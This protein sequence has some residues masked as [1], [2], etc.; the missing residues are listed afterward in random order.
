[1]VGTNFAPYFATRLGAEIKL[2]TA[3]V[4][5]FVGIPVTRIE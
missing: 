4:A 2:T 3:I 1:M 5:G